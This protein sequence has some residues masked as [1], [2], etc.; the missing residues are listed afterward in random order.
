MTPLGT[1]L[2]KFVPVKVWL[3]LKV[4]KNLLNAGSEA[5]GAYNKE[6]GP[7][8]F[9]PPQAF[10]GG[11]KGKLVKDQVEGIIEKVEAGNVETGMSHSQAALF[12]AAAS[13]FAAAIQ[14]VDFSLLFSNPRQF[15]GLLFTA[16]VVAWANYLNEPNRSKVDI[17]SNKKVADA[18]K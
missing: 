12:A 14:G 5:T 1:W 10:L 8:M 2:S 9:M 6:A 17:G 15:A 4:L 7:Q 18:V 13:I 16:C 3:V 11:L